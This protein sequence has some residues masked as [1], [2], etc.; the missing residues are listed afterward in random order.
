MSAPY[1]VDTLKERFIDLLG[2]TVICPYCGTETEDPCCGE[3]H[4]EAA[5]LGPDG[6]II[7]EDELDEAFETWKESQI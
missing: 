6:E 5:F 7:R 3:N 1:L 2:E 4:N